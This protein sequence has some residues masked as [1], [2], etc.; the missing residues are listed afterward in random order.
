MGV[1][2]GVT[3]GGLVTSKARNSL[4]ALAQK[5]FHVTLALSQEV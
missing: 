3:H 2:H 4:K 5:C 1:L